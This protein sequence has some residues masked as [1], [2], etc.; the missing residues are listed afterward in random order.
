MFISTVN[1]AMLLISSLVAI[2]LGNWIVFLVILVAIVFFFVFQLYFRRRNIQI[3]RLEAA[4]RAPPISHLGSTLDGLDS[5]RSYRAV[6][7]FE[8]QTSAKINFNTT[9]K[10]AQV[11]S[12][13]Q[14]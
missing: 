4:S 3:Q 14:F 2:V 8:E 13:K 11:L 6:Q 10:L 12:T 5:I 9:D 7:R 1:A